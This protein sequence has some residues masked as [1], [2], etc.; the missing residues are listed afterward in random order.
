MFIITPKATQQV[1]DNVQV[2]SW[3]KLCEGFA[4][5]HHFIEGL[6]DG[7]VENEL[8]PKTD[9]DVVHCGG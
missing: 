8:M 5:D 4:V 1:D 2:E 3:Q 9:F 7:M 6:V